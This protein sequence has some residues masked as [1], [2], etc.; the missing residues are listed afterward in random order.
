[1]KEMNAVVF[2]D[3]DLFRNLCT[4]I[5][6]SKNVHVTVYSSPSLYI[7]MQPGIETCPID[8]ACTNFLLTDNRMPGM[9]GLKFLDQIKSMDCKI[10]DCRKAIISGNWLDE[11]MA[12]A[13]K[14]VSNVFHKSHSKEQISE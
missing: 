10:P 6:I 13:K 8:V 4:R 14:M 11:D 5:F 2:D 9:T 7:C 12:E 3:D 1:M